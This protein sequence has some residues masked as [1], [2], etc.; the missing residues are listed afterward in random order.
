[1]ERVPRSASG[2]ERLGLAYLLDGR[3]EA[4]APLLRE[5]LQ[6]KPDAPGLRGYLAQALE[7]HARAL[8]A[9]GKVGEAEALLGEA[10]ALAAAKPP[11]SRPAARP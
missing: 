5:A 8:Q 2:P 7:G 9:Q 6:R 3:Y 10:R 1:M 11:E 4:A